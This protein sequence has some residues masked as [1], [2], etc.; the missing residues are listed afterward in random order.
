LKE[1]NINA[2]FLDKLS[3][4]VQ[5]YKRHVHETLSSTSIAPFFN[6]IKKYSIRH[7]LRQ[8]SLN[9]TKGKRP[10]INVCHK[11]R[12]NLMIKAFQHFYDMVMS[13]KITINI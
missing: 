8:Y 5:T 3:F 4:Y 11:G 6:V 13:K 7:I 9:I 1:N 2:I 12:H 10:A